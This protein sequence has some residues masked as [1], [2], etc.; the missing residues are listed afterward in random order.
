MLSSPANEGGNRIRHPSGMGRQ[1]QRAAA[2]VARWEE[3]RLAALPG[4]TIW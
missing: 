1:A 2:A 4:V 3:Q